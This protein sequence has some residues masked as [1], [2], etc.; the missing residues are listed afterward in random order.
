[1]ARWFLYIIASLIVLII[2]GLFTL[3]IWWDG[4]AEIALV[5]SGA[6]T[7][8]EQLARNQ[9]ENMDMWVARPDMAKAENP[10]L[11]I[12]SDD[13]ETATLEAS[14]TTAEPAKFAVFFVHPTSYFSR[15]SWNAPLGDQD[16]D[17]RAELFARGM[18]SAFAQGGDVWAPRYR[19]ATFGAFITEKPEAARAVDAAYQDIVQAFDVFLAK[20]GPDTPI[21]LAGHSQGA[22]HIARLMVERVA[23][24]PLQQRIAMAYPIGWPLSVSQDIPAM[25]LPACTTANQ[26]GCIMGWVSFAEPAEPGRFLELYSLAKG[27]DGQP[28]GTSPILC[29]NP[30]SGALNGA[31]DMTV[32]KGTLVPSQDLKTGSLIP[33]AVPARCDDQ[34]L[35]LIGDPPKMGPFV[36]P[37]NNFNVYDIPLFWANLRQ[38]VALRVAAWTPNG[39][40]AASTVTGSA[41]Q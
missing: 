41:A 21:V 12:P 40:A 3:R 18:G 32:N 4:A 31:A 28:H 7:E 27:F 35:L 37:G 34:G 22:Q 13:A 5:P 25:G 39:V 36:L 8:Q 33:Q 9:Y 19:Q 38:D 10:S 15:T 23:G 26:T 6:F 14:V 11:W 20:I 29:V 30:L 17:D 16:A 2:A 24:T 1:M